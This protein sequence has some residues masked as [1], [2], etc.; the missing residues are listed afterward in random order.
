MD[1][2]F[3]P[4]FILLDDDIIGPSSGGGAI[5]SGDTTEVGPYPGSISVSGDGTADFDG[6]L[7]E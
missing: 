7:G 3:K 6:G 4:S 5:D 2:I 1:T